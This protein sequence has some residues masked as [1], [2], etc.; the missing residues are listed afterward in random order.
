MVRYADDFVILCRSE[1]EA[2]PA[3]EPVQEWTV[4]AGLTWH[5]VKTRIVNAAPGGSFDFLGYHFER[6]RRW[7]RRKSLDKLKDT[8]RAK[9]RRG[10]GQSL[11]AVV[12]NLNR[13]WQGW[14][15]YFKHS[16]PFT[17]TA[18]DHWIRMRLRSL[19]RHRQGRTGRGRGWDHHRWPNA[20]F[21]EQGLYSLAAAHAGACQSSRR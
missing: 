14:F 3:L 17:F 11:P 13:S 4:K 7:P 10:N 8:I 2:R 19:L 9:T 12:T 21:A 18:L 5:P 20:F 6:G 15:E 16:H 1:A